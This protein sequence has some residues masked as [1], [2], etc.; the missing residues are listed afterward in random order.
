MLCIHGD[1]GLLHVLVMFGVAPGVAKY[2]STCGSTGWAGD[3]VRGV[4]S[5]TDDPAGNAPRRGRPVSGED[6]DGTPA[7]WGLATL[8]LD[9]LLVGD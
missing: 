8:R 2:G 1:A 5:I 3:W 4:L 6:C 7:P 9:G